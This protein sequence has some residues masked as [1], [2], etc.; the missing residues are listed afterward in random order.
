LPGAP[1]PVQRVVDADGYVVIDDGSD[2]IWKKKVSIHHNLRGIYRGTPGPFSE[3][4]DAENLIFNP[5][6]PL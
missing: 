6:D 2:P 1:L 4:K 3:V 5:V